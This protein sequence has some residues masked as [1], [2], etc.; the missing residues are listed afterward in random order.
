MVQPD[1]QEDGEKGVGPR[2]NNW[3]QLLPYVLYAI[4]K[5]PQSSTGISHFK[6][7]YA[8]RP[9][10]LL[11]VAREAWEDQLSAHRTLAEHVVG[12]QTRITRVMP[13]VRE[14]MKEA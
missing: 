7:F 3:D 9:R 14:H 1:P 11:D 13:I 4:R 12:M 8:H 6:L 10:G 5:V 2:G